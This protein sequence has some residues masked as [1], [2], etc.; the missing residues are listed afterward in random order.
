MRVEAQESA[1]DA[2]SLCWGAAIV[3][4]LASA[5]RW[6]VALLASPEPTKL[7]PSLVLGALAVL[8]VVRPRPP[9]LLGL[10]SVAMLVDVG[11]ALPEVPNHRLILA[12]GSVALLLALVGAGRGGG[13]D[14]LVPA[15]RTIAVLV[16]AFAFFAKLNR[17]FVDPT[18]S[19]ATQFYGHLRSWW[20][21][22]PAG[23]G[24]DRAAIFATLAIECL[25]PIGL[26][27]PR[28]RHA[29]VVLGLAFHLAL[30]CD[31]TRNLLNFSA[32]MFALLLLF[33]PREF[34][35]SFARRLEREPSLRR[36]LAAALL[37][38]VVSGLVAITD[39][40][41]FALLYYWVRQLVWMTF[42]L[43]LIAAVVAWHDRR[44]LA[45]WPVRARL[46]PSVVVGVLATLN[47]LSPYLG[48]KTR[49]A[50]DMYSNLRLEAERSNHWLVPRSLDLLGLLRDRVKILA[51]DDPALRHRYVDTG[52]ELSY[53]ELASYLGEH[54][55]RVEYR[56]GTEEFE[57]DPGRP[58]SRPPA[59][60]WWRRKL[61]VFRP[62]G[63]SSR[64][65][66]IW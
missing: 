62:L 60:P 3:F 59:P 57:V 63:E 28:T 43:V 11:L 26:L 33:L 8:V 49:T 18:A 42:G 17:D 25:L 27:W 19:C 40:E 56:R 35:E 52:D 48:L 55:A 20:L 14:A 30:G 66:C 24:V 44:R 54:P 50:F 45:P 36:I 32:V 9:W 34:F 10:L 7:M 51:T 64:S 61:L 4:S 58:A 15:G 47:G 13:F 16:Y 41:R 65:Q 1:R 6:F 29:A 21:L 22:L 23:P 38:V 39:W 46:G 5:S 31:A 53:F 2:W 37:A 12:L